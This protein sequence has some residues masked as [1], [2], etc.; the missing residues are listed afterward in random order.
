MKKKHDKQPQS[1]ILPINK[2]EHK[3]DCSGTI[4]IV[5]HSQDNAPGPSSVI[6]L[7][8]N[9]EN[10]PSYD[11]PF[12]ANFFKP[13]ADAV[14]RVF[15]DTYAKEELQQGNL[16]FIRH[17]VLGQLVYVNRDSKSAFFQQSQDT[18]SYLGKAEIKYQ[19]GIR[20]IKQLHDL[21]K[22]Q[23]R[24]GYVQKAF[25][26]H[27]TV[28]ELYRM[29]ALFT[30]GVEPGSDDLYVYQE[31]IAELVPTLANLFNTSDKN[32]Y[33]FI[34]QLQYVSNPESGNC[35]IVIKESDIKNLIYKAGWL[36]QEVG[37]LYEESVRQ[38]EIRISKMDNIST[39]VPLPYIMNDT[40]PADNIVREPGSHQPGTAPLYFCA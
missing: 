37:R 40:D 16:Y 17:C 32:E 7:L 27:E 38:C 6:T 28:L 39:K 14:Y 2:S 26:L 1:E 18:G 25:V 30:V 15:S 22:R 10:T 35:G 21:M 9:E 13:A 36:W 29:A 33:E 11:V 8:M 31:H 5:F 3:Q 23:K 12:N 24:R 20:K 34:Q 19:M 4:V